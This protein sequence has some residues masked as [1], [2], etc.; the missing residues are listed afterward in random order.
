MQA[1]QAIYQNGKPLHIF[2]GLESNRVLSESVAAIRKLSSMESCQ[3]TLINIFS[4]YV[5]KSIYS[6]NGFVRFFCTDCNV[7]ICLLFASRRLQVVGYNVLD[8]SFFTVD[9]FFQF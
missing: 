4:V 7:F 1:I 5:A 6:A 3:S 9:I 2:E 8:D